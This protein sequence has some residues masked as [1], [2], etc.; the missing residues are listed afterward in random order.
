MS[1][2]VVDTRDVRQALNAVLPHAAKVAVIPE[3]C[4]VRLLPGP[5]NLEV[6]ATDRTTIGFAIVAI[7]DLFDGELDPIDLHVDDVRKVLS[8]FPEWLP[9]G[10]GSGNGAKPA[11]V[12]VL[13]KPICEAD[14]GDKD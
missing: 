5:Q 14:F 12:R 4:H 10:G 3:L 7:L 1:S 8:V 2:F 13:T 11:L 6:S 9:N